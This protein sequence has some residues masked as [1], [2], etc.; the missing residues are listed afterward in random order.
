MNRRGN[1]E[2]GQPVARKD[3]ERARGPAAVGRPGSRHEVGEIEG[4][5][6]GCHELAGPAQSLR[7]RPIVR[8][9]NVEALET[10]RSERAAEIHRGDEASRGE[11]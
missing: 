2:I 4:K 5:G 1:G 7:L 3:E 11:P 9:E 6:T 8:R 10:F